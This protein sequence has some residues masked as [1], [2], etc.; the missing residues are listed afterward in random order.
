MALLEVREDGPY[1]VLQPERG[2]GLVNR[3][4]LLWVPGDNN[5]ALVG[6]AGQHEGRRSGVHLRRLVDQ[7]EVEPRLY[8]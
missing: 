5:A 6:E 2:F 7:D 8:R 4:K 1:N 3:R